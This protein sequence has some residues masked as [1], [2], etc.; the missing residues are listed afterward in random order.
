MTT[1]RLLMK[2]QILAVLA[3]A[4]IAP[5]AIAGF[6]YSWQNDAD[7]FWDISGSIEFADEVI[8]GDIIDS[9][10]S[11][12]AF[13]FLITDPDGDY[14][15]QFGRDDIQM[16]LESFVV[17]RG[18][19]LSVGKKAA[20]KKKA[21]PVIEYN[22]FRLETENAEIDFDIFNRKVAKKK[23]GDPTPILQAS[24]WNGYGFAGL[25]DLAQEPVDTGGAKKKALKKAKLDFYGEWTTT[26][27]P[28]PASFGLMLIGLFLVGGLRRRFLR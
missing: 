20:K 9:V 23:A 26:A 5:T 6:I 8:F 1:A 2:H 27:L 11:I 15:I 21:G 17:E 24:L 14:G 22:T 10:D 16:N 3:A 4:I 13:D 12:S 19:L 18:G 28:E 25:D 7:N